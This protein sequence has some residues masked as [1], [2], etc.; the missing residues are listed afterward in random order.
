MSLSVLFP[1]SKIQT[2]RFNALIRPIHVR[3]PEFPFFVAFYLNVKYKKSLRR[4]VISSNKFEQFFCVATP[5]PKKKSG[6][7]SFCI[8][9]EG[10]FLMIH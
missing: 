8:F 1:S 5:Q 7:L 10:I 9:S 2:F 6:K 4:N 3:F